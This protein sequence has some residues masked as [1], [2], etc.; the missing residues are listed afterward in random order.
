[1]VVVLKIEYGLSFKY[2]NSRMLDCK[3]PLEMVCL[4]YHL[5]NLWIILF[6]PPILPFVT[7]YN[8]F[9]IPISLTNSLFGD[10]YFEEESVWKL[11]EFDMEKVED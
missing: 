5:N 2:L 6:P 10:I 7:N 1:L 11:K 4:I 9:T 8:P 3:F